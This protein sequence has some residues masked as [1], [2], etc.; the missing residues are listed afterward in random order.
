[1]DTAAKTYGNALRRVIGFGMAPP[2]VLRREVTAF[3][4]EPGMP[5]A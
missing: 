3:S 4:Q 1:M 2:Y 5:A